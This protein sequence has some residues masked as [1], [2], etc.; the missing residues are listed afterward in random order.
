MAREQTEQAIIKK[1]VFSDMGVGPN[2]KINFLIINT[3]FVGEFD[4]DGKSIGGEKITVSDSK[5][6]L[7]LSTN[8]LIK[9][10]IKDPVY[11]YLIPSPEELSESHGMK[12]FG[13]RFNP[14][15]YYSPHEYLEFVKIDIR[16][17]KD[18]LHKIFSS[19]NKFEYLEDVVRVWDEIKIP[20]QKEIKKFY[21]TYY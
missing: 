2:G 21:D 15:N 19:Q 8:N 3:G 14:L 16:E 5:N 1:K 17:R 6:L 9:N 13:E 11:G 10:W 12:N 4:L 18:F 20:H 7:H